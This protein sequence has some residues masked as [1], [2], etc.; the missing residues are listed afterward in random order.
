MTDTEKKK[1]P[2]SASD[3]ASVEQKLLIKLNEIEDDITR[4]RTPLRLREAAQQTV[5]RAYSQLNDARSFQKTIN[6]LVDDVVK[7]HVECK[8]EQAH[9]ERTLRTAFQKQY[10]LL[11]SAETELKKMHKYLKTYGCFEKS[12]SK[13]SKI[14][15]DEEEKKAD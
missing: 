8:L 11:G 5:E 3:S 4:L 10:E 9:I 2:L 13:R 6:W 14:E 12:E 15:G 7:V 1:Q